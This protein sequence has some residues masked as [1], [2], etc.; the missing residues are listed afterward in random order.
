[1]SGLASEHT[2]AAYTLGT[3]PTEGYRLNIAVAEGPDA[4]AL[5]RH[6]GNFR[7]LISAKSP[8]ELKP[9][10]VGGFWPRRVWSGIGRAGPG[11]PGRCRGS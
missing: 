6:E 7:F 9:P 2:L 5:Y 11:S 1:M 8:V 3:G 10:G 4:L